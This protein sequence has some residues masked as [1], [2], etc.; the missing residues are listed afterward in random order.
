MQAGSRLLSGVLVALSF[1]VA[2]AAAQGRQAPGHSIGTISTQGDLIV[3]TLD[4]GALGKANFFDLA[5][6]TVRFNRDGSAYRVENVPLQWD[7]D[8]GPQMSGSRANLNKFSFPFSGKE[9]QSLTVGLTGTI[10]FGAPDGAELAIDRFAQLQRAARTLIDGVPAICTFFKPRMTGARYFKELDDRAV[11]TWSLS[12]PVGNI[13]DFTWTPT[14]NRFQA[15][16]RKDGSIEMSYERVTAKDAIV[17]VYPK[18][19][20]GAA[21]ETGTVTP[22]GFRGPEVDLSSLKLTDGPFTV[23]YEA[24]HYLA[25]PNSRDL[26]CTVIKALGDKFD[27]LTYY[28]DFRVDN[29]EAGT[30]SDGP[31]GPGLSP[32]SVTGIGA[33]QRGLENYCT[34]GRFQW[35]FIQPVY[36]GSNQMQER[37]PAR[38]SDR[39]RATSRLMRINWEN[40]HRTASS[41]PTITPCHR[42]GMNWAIA[43]RRSFRRR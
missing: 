4:E 5:G 13:Q 1:A 22:S 28:S 21:G 39:T 27:F 38:M 23:A 41:R 42:S 3:M 15:V 33:N 8:F 40:A 24:F 26:A 37:P 34:Q 43:G 20:S 11:I 35:E 32:V 19:N 16:L 17:G 30:P 36:V 14:V 18:V 2:H 7:S 10:S 31:N 29:Q 12:E 25:L 6:R 9:W